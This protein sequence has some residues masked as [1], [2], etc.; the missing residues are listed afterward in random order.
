MRTAVYGLLHGRR[1][2]CL[3]FPTTTGDGF[4]DCWLLW[5]A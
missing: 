1:Y 2:V 5:T 3:A 4:A